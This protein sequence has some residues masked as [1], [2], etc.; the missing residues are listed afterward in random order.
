MTLIIVADFLMALG[1]LAWTAMDVSPWGHPPAYGLWALPLVLRSSLLAVVTPGEWRRLTACV[2]ILGSLAFGAAVVTTDLVAPN[3]VFTMTFYVAIPLFVL[4][5]LALEETRAGSLLRGLAPIAASAARA[6]AAILIIVFLSKGIGPQEPRN[7]FSSGHPGP[8]IAGWMTATAASVLTVSFLAWWAC[9]L[10]V[11]QSARAVWLLAVLGTVFESIGFAV[12]AQNVDDR[13]ALYIGIALALVVGHVVT[14]LSC[15]LMAGITP[16]LP[17]SLVLRSFGV[18]VAGLGVAC[19]VWTAD[20]LVFGVTVLLEAAIQVPWFLIVA[21]RLEGL[22]AN[23]IALA[24]GHGVPW[25]DDNQVRIRGADSEN[26]PLPGATRV[27][28]LPCHHG[29]EAGL[30]EFSTHARS[31]GTSFSRMS[32]TVAG[33]TRA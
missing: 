14:S 3:G 12:V 4:T 27:V 7:P 19:A 18:C 9:R 17:K 30:I 23:T 28:P 11:G 21:R 22:K 33:S 31:G 20:F 8:W 15:A 26:S 10:H 6:T 29:A 2:G 13:E 1:L 24:A 32:Q 5:L 25:V 16:G